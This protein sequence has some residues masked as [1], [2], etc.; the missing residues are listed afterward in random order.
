MGVHEFNV[1]NFFPAGRGA[2]LYSEMLT[3]KKLMAVKKEYYEIRQQYGP[4]ELILT[5][6]G[7][8]GPNTFNPQSTSAKLAEEGKY[9]YA[10]SGAHGQM[11]FIDVN[12]NVFGCMTQ[13]HLNLQIGT[14]SNEGELHLY[15]KTPLDNFHRKDCFTMKY[16]WEK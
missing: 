12:Q 15:E 7:M 11:I 10:G 3:A 9:C 14:I 6:T 13:Q 8:L 4:D 5:R 1:N 16:L 2:H